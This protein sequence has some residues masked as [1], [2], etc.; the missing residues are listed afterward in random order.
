MA[1]Q[2]KAALTAVG[3]DLGIAVAKFVA[4]SFTGSSGLLSEAVHSLVDAGNSSLLILG[5]HRGARPADETHPFGYGKE[6]YFWTLLVALFIFCVGG[7]FSIVEGIGRLRHPHSIEHP[8][9]SYITLIVAAAFEGYSLHVGLR[10]F[11]EAEDRPASWRAIHASKDPSTFTVIIEDVAALTGLSIAFSF[12]L[13]DQLLHWPQADGIGSI[14]IGVVLVAVAVVLIVESKDLLIGEGVDVATLRRIR[15]LAEAQ[16]GV[17]AAG[18]PLTMFFGPAQVL[19]TM[20]IRFQPELTRDGIEQSIDGIEA[21][22][23]AQFPQIKHI[24][25]EAESIRRLTQDFDP[26]RLPDPSPKPQPGHSLRH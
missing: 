17:Y 6:V 15:Q 5:L 11:R 18:Y 23:R 16:P 14:L 4:F 7:G 24:Y 21:A 10:E 12:T 9:W 3:A 25:L 19:L 1:S 26:T 20:N 22:V 2:R 8:L 13:L